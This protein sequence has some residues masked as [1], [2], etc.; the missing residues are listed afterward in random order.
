MVHFLE[1]GRMLS[2]QSSLQ[3][4]KKSIPKT[5][6][7]WAQTQRKYNKNSLL[8][9]YLQAQERHKTAQSTSEV[10]EAHWPEIC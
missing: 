5:L 4:V 7:M 10:E 2:I 1:A 8:G 3:G 6:P 9:G